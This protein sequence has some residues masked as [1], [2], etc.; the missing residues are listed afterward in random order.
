VPNRRRYVDDQKYDNCR[1]E[2][3]A[4]TNRDPAS[5]AKAQSPTDTVVRI[6][7]ELSA[8]N[9]HAK[10]SAKIT[11]QT[12]TACKCRAKSEKF[13]KSAYFR[14]FSPDFLQS[15]GPNHISSMQATKAAPA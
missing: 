15:A 11:S 6:K 3:K 13:M 12:C 14:R 8:G 9:R 4:Q 1:R 7:K 2:L 5:D 10:K